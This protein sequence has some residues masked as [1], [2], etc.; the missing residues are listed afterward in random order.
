MLEIKDRIP[1]YPGRVK[2]VPVEGQP[3]TYDMVRADEPIE[4]GTPINKALFDDILRDFVALRTQVNSTLYTISHRA[5]LG[6]IAPGTEIVLEEN[7]V[8]VP[9]I[10]IQS[11]YGGAAGSLLLRKHCVTKMPLANPNDTKYPDCRA[12]LWLNNE[13]FSML[14]ATERAIALEA[15]FDSRIT[16]YSGVS[17]T[18]GTYTYR[19]KVFLLSAYE[20][21]ITPGS[22]ISYEGGQI[23]YFNSAARRVATFNGV[24]TDCY[25]RTVSYRPL[26]GHVITT[27]GSVSQIANPSEYEAGIRPVLF[28][29]NT[30][31]VSVADPNTENVMANAEVI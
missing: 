23:A 7:G 25:T 14:G 8:L 31:E 27:A 18:S 3:N 15:P 22:G 6:D 11:S 17:S 28:L 12:D 16:E 21:G 2:M 9:F 19:R 1:T 26:I 10:K 29:P 20:Q 4:P 5:L 24:P 30:Y 13:Y